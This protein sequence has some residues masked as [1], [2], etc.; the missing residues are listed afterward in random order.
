MKNNNMELAQ[1]SKTD[2]QQK[3]K[4]FKIETTVM[5][6]V[7]DSYL[8]GAQTCEVQKGKILGVSIHQGACDSIHLFINDDHKVTVEV[9]QD[10]IETAIKIYNELSKLSPSRKVS[11]KKHKA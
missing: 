11:W 7:V 8:H 6:L 4:H 10:H 5:K 3:P 2:D 1:D 9:S